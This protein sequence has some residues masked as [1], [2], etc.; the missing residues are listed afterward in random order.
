ML[1]IL[2]YR[3]RPVLTAYRESWWQSGNDCRMPGGNDAVARNCSLHINQKQTCRNDCPD[4]NVRASSRHN[5]HCHRRRWNRRS[6][7]GHR[8]AQGR[9][10]CHGLLSPFNFTSI[11]IS[12]L[13][14]FK[15]L[16]Q[17]SLLH[18]TSAAITITP[19]AS[20]VL[21]A[22]GLDASQAKMV[23]IK[24]RSLVNGTTLEAVIPNYFS[25]VEET[26]GTP[27]YSVHRVDLHNQLRALATRKEGQG[28]PVDIQV[29]T[30]VVNYV[31][32]N[33]DA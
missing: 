25:N 11:T 1:H 7:C 5:G 4:R 19:N 31:R 33:D 17:S 2:S 15:I 14:L 3:A 18:E 23:A 24:T 22:W 12:K 32:V 29:R 21:R 13:L 9:T 16:E 26:W 8:P 30:Q 20:K 28:Q 10:Q 27:L 6:Q